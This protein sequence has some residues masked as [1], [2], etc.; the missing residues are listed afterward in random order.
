L[1]PSDVVHSAEVLDML[2]AIFG[3]E[4]IAMGSDYPYPLGELDMRGD[5]KI[6]PGHLIQYHPRLAPQERER[7]L[8]G[9]AREWLGVI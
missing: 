1:K 5:K 3:A 2:L 4:R 8:S 6:Y 9:T 7:L